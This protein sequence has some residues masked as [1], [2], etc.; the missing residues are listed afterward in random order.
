MSKCTITEE[1]LFKALHIWAMDLH[2]ALLVRKSYLAHHYQFQEDAR[3]LVHH[4]EALSISELTIFDY[5]Y[6]NFLDSAKCGYVDTLHFPALMT[7]FKNWAADDTLLLF[8]LFHTLFHLISN[9]LL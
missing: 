1:T 4:L 7:G 5:L 9:S 8:L 3:I 6:E 2:A